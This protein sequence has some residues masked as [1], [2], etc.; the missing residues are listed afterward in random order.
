[1]TYKELE[2]EIDGTLKSVVNELKNL[3]EQYPDA[4][5][6]V[7]TKDI[8]Y[9]NEQLVAVAYLDVEENHE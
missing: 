4:T 2:I 1:M 5:I 9:Y 6:G 7:K 8:G 3:L